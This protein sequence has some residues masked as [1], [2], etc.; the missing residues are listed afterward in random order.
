[1]QSAFVVH[2]S[3]PAGHAPVM[4]G[5]AQRPIPAAP[6]PP[7]GQQIW[8]AVHGIAPLAAVHIGA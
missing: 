6:P 7:A 3:A 1:L 8:P 2:S 4:A 5:A